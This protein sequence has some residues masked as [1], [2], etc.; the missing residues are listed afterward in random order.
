MSTDEKLHQV[1][2]ILR[3]I[4]A[5]NF[6]I[7]VIADED[8]FPFEPYIVIRL[9]QITNKYII[10]LS[11]LLGSLPTDLKLETSQLGGVP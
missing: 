3:R 10:E 4:Q 2:E 7:M 6:I 5:L 11:G 1:E 9:T 8:K